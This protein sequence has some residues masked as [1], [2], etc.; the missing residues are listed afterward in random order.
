MV[1]AGGSLNEHIPGFN[2]VRWR[3]L[4]LSQED[5]EKFSASRDR[6]Q[7]LITQAST[8]GHLGVTPDPPRPPPVEPELPSDDENVGGPPLDEPEPPAVLTDD[9]CAA[10]VRARMEGFAHLYG[11]AGGGAVSHTFDP[12]IILAF[13]K[14]AENLKAGADIAQSLIDAGE[15]FFGRRGTQRHLGDVGRRGQH[16]VP[17]LNLLRAGRQRLDLLS[18]LF[19]RRLFLRF[20]FWRYLIIDGSPI[21]GFSFEA[22]REDRIAIPLST[23]SSLLGMLGLDLNACYETRLGVLTTTGYG[24]SGVVKKLSNLLHIFLQQCPSKEEFTRQRRQV[25]NILTDQGTEKAVADSGFCLPGF[26]HHDPGTPESWAYPECLYIAGH[27][28]IIFNA[29]EE[30]IKQMDGYHDYITHL[31]Y[32]ETLLSDKMLRRKFQSILP[33][34]LRDLFKAYSTVHIDWRWEMLSKALV[35]LIP[36]LSILQQHFDV[37]K[38]KATDNKGRRVSTEKIANCAKALRVPFIAEFSEMIRCVGHILEE[39][40]HKLEGCLCHKV[41][42]D[43]NEIV[44]GGWGRAGRGGGRCVWGGGG[45]GGV[46]V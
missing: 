22:T 39:F 31:N 8:A 14:Y 27:L 3:A 46:L 33:L 2:C 29:L 4:K 1:D 40:A 12:S 26:P 7:F 20:E 30:A 18:M 5:A 11:H 16:M 6:P 23:C 13:L 37:E 10:H 44:N 25:K 43:I 38:M 9:A 28:H 17:S 19:E 15:I 45:L 35:V 21:F 34:P 41:G 24:K 42:R 36:L 32:I